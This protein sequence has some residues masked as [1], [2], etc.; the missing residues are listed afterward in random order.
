MAQKKYQEIRD[1]RNQGE[2]MI[3]A[4]KINM[5]RHFV[6]CEVICAAALLT[7]CVMSAEAQSAASTASAPAQKASLTTRLERLQAVRDVQ[8]L[9]SRYTYYQSADMQEETIALFAQHTPGTRAE[10]MWGIYDG[11]DSIKKCYLLDHLQKK[12]TKARTGVMHIDTLT[13][14]I[15]QVAGDGKTAKGI[16]MSPGLDSSI[17]DGKP[18]ADWAWFKYGTDFIKE[19]GVWKIWHLHIYG[20]FVSEYHKSWAEGTQIKYDSSYTG[21]VGHKM[22]NDRSPSTYWMFSADTVFPD[23]QP[24]IPAPYETFDEKTA[25]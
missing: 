22:H 21:L 18:E 5:I 2:A 8:N 13:T 9:M 25:F 16:W 1:S 23:D 14:P 19:D 20:I 7:L 12:D 11:L 4:G 24:S 6:L 10:M 17:V 15:I 3:H